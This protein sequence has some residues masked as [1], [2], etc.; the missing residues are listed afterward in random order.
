MHL[1]DNSDLLRKAEEKLESKNSSESKFVH[2]LKVYQIELEIQ[3][4]ELRNTE[5][6]LQTSR[7][8]YIRLYNQAPVGYLTVDQS[9]IIRQ[10]NDTFTKMKGDPLSDPRGKALA[11][12]ICEEDRPSFLGRFRAFFKNPEGKDIDVA[13]R[14]QKPTITVRLSGSRERGA[15][16]ERLLIIVQDISVR[17][18]ADLKIHS[19][20]EEKEIILQEV[21]HRVK[22]NM[23]TIMGL[24]SLQAAKLTNSEAAEVL[25]DAR[26]RVETMLLI[27]DSLY[28]SGNYRSVDMKVYIS[29]LLKRVELTFSDYTN[30]SIRSTLEPL[31][32]E[33]STAL[34]MGIIINELVT[35]AYKY[36]FPDGRKGTIE[37]V[38]KKNENAEVQLL[39]RDNGS[40]IPDSYSADTSKGFG[41]TLVH[42][43]AGHMDGGINIS[44]LNPG[45]EFSIIMKKLEEHLPSSP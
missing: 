23:N 33:A 35:N 19:L 4:E 32:L 18:A 16:D 5:E 43:L 39:V 9:G 8:Q 27:Y 26:H 17:K 30:I 36:A 38:L 2:D 25:I 22:N 3:N 15:K 11:D 14:R 31:T 21:H 42:G 44:R 6:A 29:D 34:N 7:D 45:T 20:L 40:G 13:L 12:F 24:L 28:R 1:M 37:L 41:L 10:C